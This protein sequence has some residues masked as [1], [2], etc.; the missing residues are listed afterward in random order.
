MDTL[1]ARRQMVE[2]QIRTWEVLDGRVLDVLGRVPREEFVPAAY[3]A[4]AFADVSIPIGRCQ[5]MLA[6]SLQGRI[7]QALAIG[8]QDRVLEIGTGTGYLSACMSLLAGAAKSIDIHAGFRR[9][10]GHQPAD[11]ARCPGRARSARRVRRRA[12]RRIRRDRRDRIDAALRSAFRTVADGR[13]SPLCDRRR[14]ACDGGD[15]RP[16]R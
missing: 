14:R 13:R 10:S 16:P 8:P 9:A 1:A 15:P 2:Q 4:V 3:R 6:P 5:M 11:G 7:L 12:A